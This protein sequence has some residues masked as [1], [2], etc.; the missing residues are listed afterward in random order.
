M[1][2]ATSAA[3]SA[4]GRPAHTTRVAPA[5][6][7]TGPGLFPY[8]LALPTALLLLV[9]LCYPFYEGVRLSLTDASLLNPRRAQFV[10]FANYI[11]LLGSPRLASILR[12][13]FV[14]VVASVVGTLALGMLAAL[15]MNLPRRGRA[16]IRGL[17][18]IPWAV[19][20]VAVALI[21][22]WLFNNQYG[23]VN[24]LLQRAGII[25]NYVRWLDNPALALPALIAITIWMTFP[26]AAIVILAALQSVD[27]DVLE[28]ASMDGA[29]GLSRFRNVTLPTITPT[30]IT[31]A[32]FLTIWAIRR[33]EI[34]WIL[35]QGGPVGSTGTMVVELY[36]TAFRHMD[37]GTGAALGTVGLGISIVVTVVFVALA[38]R[39]DRAH[40]RVSST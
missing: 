28:A 7:D 18:A 25:D 4:K 26:F 38:A 9:L 39:I 16:V 17:I 13:T 33:F 30:L 27:S 24:H 12:V 21:F 15:A 40:G 29:R 10:W 14:Y 1:T 35:T 3:K 31:V 34:I 6:R 32:L 23:L 2:M 5:R 11:D 37:L 20:Q 22:A 8:L 36:R 19:P